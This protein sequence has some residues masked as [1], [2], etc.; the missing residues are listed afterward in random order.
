M[1]MR[2]ISKT[3]LM[4]LVCVCGAGFE[5]RA[6][7]ETACARPWIFFDMG[8]TVTD[9]SHR[10]EYG[11]FLEEFYRPGVVNYLTDL[12]NAGYPIGM[13][14]NIP[15][16]MTMADLK[17]EVTEDFKQSHLKDGAVF[18]WS[19]FENSGG[20]LI[21]GKN[22]RRKPNRYMFC[23]AAEAAARAGC[24]AI[25][26]GEDLLNPDKKRRSHLEAAARAG[27]ASFDIDPAR[28][29]AK[30]RPY[31]RVEGGFI[32]IEEIRTF[33]RDNPATKA[34]ADYCKGYRK[35]TAADADPD[36]IEVRED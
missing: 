36:E 35:R 26:Q 6:G 11:D 17:A 30:D 21:P 3:A 29:P 14:I 28:A 2:S 23:K 5:T 8:N 7:A 10:D 34:S 9:T 24:R 32:A 13:I 18:D 4:T 19:A 25:Y 20:V 1:V 12:Q 33:L 27:I 22:F 16:T 31:R 15:E